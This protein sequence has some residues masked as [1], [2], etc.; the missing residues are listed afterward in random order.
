MARAAAD[1]RIDIAMGPQ[2]ADRAASA[3]RGRRS[4]FL[5]AIAA[6]LALLAF[7][8][9][10]PLAQGVPFQRGVTMAEFGPYGL[11]P[12]AT[13]AKFRYLKRND[14]VNSVTL[15]VVWMQADKTSTDIQ[16][17][18][19]TVRED[20]LTA[21]IKAAHKVGL[22]VVLRPYVDI[23]SGS[24]RGDIAPASVPAWFASYRKFIL[25][26]A[27]LAQRLRVQGFIVGSELETMAQYTADWQ[28]LIGKVRS[29]FKGWLSYEANWDGF[30][31]VP[32]WSLLDAIDVSAYFPLADHPYPSVAELVQGWHQLGSKSWFDQVAAA[33]R[34]YGKPVFFGE[35]GYRTV[36]GAAMMPFDKGD[37]PPS[38]SAQTRAYLAAFKVWYRVPWFRGFHWWYIPSKGSLEGLFG[39]DYVP[40]AG[41][42]RVLRSWYHKKR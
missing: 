18:S 4:I 10:P 19:E 26:Y 15:L 28:S 35:I 21:A 9:A 32:F 11:P 7:G 12:V 40:T 37:G 38:N 22:K 1:V 13:K 34:R 8:A 14:G 17:G 29:R 42:E 36:A 3:G 31:R 5:A 16:P 6:A 24:W 33:H 27:G 39:G 23:Y 2:Q 41:T 25:H 20:R 30:R